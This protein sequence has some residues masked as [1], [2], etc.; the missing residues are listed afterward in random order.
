[1]NRLLNF[2]PSPSTFCSWNESL[3]LRLSLFYSD[4]TCNGP[5]C[6]Y[7]VRRVFSL[8]LWLPFYYF[9][10][11]SEAVLESNLMNTRLIQQ[12]AKWAAQE[13]RRP[14][15]CSISSL[16]VWLMTSGPHI[17]SVTPP[18]PFHC[19]YD[20]KCRN[21]TAGWSAECFRVLFETLRWLSAGGRK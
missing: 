20:L 21:Y 1:M 7:K 15:Y 8:S 19:I 13:G 14:R 16:S 2:Y 17:T 18:P 3:C 12:I 5:M 4:S 9:F 10:S 11:F 6:W